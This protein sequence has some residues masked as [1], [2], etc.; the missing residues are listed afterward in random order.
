MKT[1]NMPLVLPAVLLVTALI[2]GCATPAAESTAV[3][4]TQPQVTVSARPYIPMIAKASSQ[5]PFWRIVRSGAEKAAKEFN[6]D[7]TFEGPDIDVQVDKQIAMLQAAL[8]KKPAAICLAASDS[9]AEI[10]LLQ[11]ASDAQI[12]VIGFDSGV[13]SDIPVATATTNNIAAAAAAADHLAQLIGNTGEVAIIGFDQPSRSGFDRVKG[14]TD[15][16]TAKYPK[17]TIVSTDYG[18]GDVLKSSNL[19]KAVIR[20]HPKLKGYF[21]ANQGSVEGLLD[22]VKDMKKEGQIVVVGFDSGSDQIAA[23]RNGVEAGAITQDP[24][25]IG[26]RCIEAAV[27]AIQGQTLPKTIDTAWHWYDKTNLDDPSLAPLLYR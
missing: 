19:V 27:K 23:I 15:E 6:V 17:I 18:A 26:Y 14:F 12:P 1:K 4:T 24:I 11:K 7:T 5:T 13:D 3:P 20:D 21:G 2:A 22:A 9:Q 16:M 8:A 10:P 25:D